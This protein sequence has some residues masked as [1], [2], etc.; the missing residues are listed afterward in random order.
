[1]IGSEMIVNKIDKIRKNNNYRRFKRLINIYIKN[2][3]YLT[4]SIK[5][6]IIQ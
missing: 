3:S 6:I 4:H 1:M 2:I 5:E